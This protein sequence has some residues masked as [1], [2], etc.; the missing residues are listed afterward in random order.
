[1]SEMKKQRTEDQLS[2]GYAAFE[3][4]GEMKPFSY[5]LRELSENDIVIRVT[6]CGIC[7]S[8]IHQIDNDWSGSVYPIVPGHEI[9]G[10]VIEVGNNV[11][12]FKV[13]DRAAVGCYVYSC[14]KCECC[15]R[16]EGNYCSKAVFTYND[17][18]PDGNPTY[19]GYCNR[20]VIDENFANTVPSEISS[21]ETG[22]LMC[23]GV[24][25]YSPMKHFGLKAGNKLAIIGFGGLGHMAAKFGKAFGC[26]V[27]MISTSPHKESEAKE[28]GVHFLLSSNQEQ[29]RKTKDCFDMILSTVAGNA[30]DLNVY[31][32]MLK[33]NGKFIFLGISTEPH[34]FKVQSLVFKRL[35]LAGSLVSS[36]EEAQEMLEFCA[37]HHITP[38]IEIYP[39]SKINEAVHR[40]RQGKDIKHTLQN[41]PAPLGIET[42]KKNI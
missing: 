33:V 19:G 15:Q 17:F 10:T 31:L 1:M 27:T 2:R 39:I 34:Q 35:T 25:V 30:L 21:E 42:M 29:M 26:E 7:H 40:V 41:F 23:A 6:H 13:S 11:K 38:K 18:L 24:T 28:L 22:P 9:V 32:S 20:L 37:K 14:G 12:K 36:V 5:P 4:K 8:D 3:V 16:K